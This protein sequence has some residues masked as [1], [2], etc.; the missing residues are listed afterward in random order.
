LDSRR[1]ASR[2]CPW[3]MEKRK[4][5]FEIGKRLKQKEKLKRILNLKNL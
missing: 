1:G 3:T 4:N 5:K 2:G